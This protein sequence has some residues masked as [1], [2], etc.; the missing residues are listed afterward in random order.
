MNVFRR[1]I[2]LEDLA[3]CAFYISDDD[4]GKADEFV[5]AF[6]ESV[7]RLAQMPYVGA[8]YSTENPALYGL[9]RWLIKGFEKYLIFYLVFEDTIDVVRILHSARDIASILEDDA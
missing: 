3:D 7:A 8:A 1:D 5:D 4:P 2:A 9:R 6:E